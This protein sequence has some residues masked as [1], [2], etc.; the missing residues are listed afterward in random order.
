M[1]TSKMMKTKNSKTKCSVPGNQFICDR[2]DKDDYRKILE[3]TILTMQRVKVKCKFVK[4]FN[5]K[6]PVS[7]TME[8]KQPQEAE[9]SI[10]QAERAKASDDAVQKALAAFGGTIK[11]E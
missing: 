8:L 2:L 4:E 7:Q 11:E 1:T 5:G 9:P 3:E 10:P 6:V